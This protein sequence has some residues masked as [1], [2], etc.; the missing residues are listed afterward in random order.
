M[1]KRIVILAIIFSISSVL[2]AGEL[3]MR[4]SVE[5]VIEDIYRQLL[6]V[7]EV[8]YEELQEELM[9]FAVEPIDLNNSTEAELMR[10]RF[11]TPQQTDAILLYA[12]KHPFETVEELD[13]ISE[14][15]PYEVRNLKAFVT[16]KSKESDYQMYAKEVFSYAKHEVTARVDV[17]NIENYN[18]DPVY[19]QFKY[20]FNYQNRVQFGAG[21]CRNAGVPAKEMS[22]GA[23][24]QLN[25]I[26]PH[27]H[28]LVAGNYQ[29]S[30]GQGLVLNSGFHMGKSSYVLTAGNAPEGLKKYSSAGRAALH[31]AGATLEFGDITRLKTEVSVL[32]GMSRSNDSAWKHTIG[33]NLTFKHRLLKVGVTAVEN[34]Y[35]DSLRYY[36]ETAKYNQNYFR[37]NRQAVIGVNFRYNY[38][39]FDLFGEVAAAQNKKWGYGTEIGCR[40][41]PVSD[42]GL[43]VLC[44]YYSPTFDNTMGYGFSETSRI[45]DEHGIYLGADIKRLKNWR[46]EVYGDVFRFSGIKYGINFAPS[47]GYD[48]MGQAE[49]L[50][51]RD[52]SM[53]WR[54]R[55][56]DKGKKGVYSLRY[57]FNWASSGWQLRT[58]ADANFGKDHRPD[59]ETPVLTYGISV[60]QDIQ[61][62]FSQVPIVLQMRLQGFDVRQWDNRLYVYE[63][64]VLYAF[65]IPAT[66]GTGGRFYLNFRWRILPQLALYLRVSETIYSK[67]WASQRDIPQ[68]RTDIHLLLRATL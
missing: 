33:A 66:Y 14:L 52:W 7:G 9:E 64:D 38:G 23:Y 39:W 46:F 31:G 11:L 27:L 50:P 54:L 13:L 4:G 32:Y 2:L 63:N 60:H 29:A 48:V 26:A 44:R 57:Q 6:E 65:S 22:Y 34:L 58:Q 36:Y 62:R 56:R 28:T 20:K 61:Y 30:F 45:N 21:L 18:N 17:R 15:Q 43:V 42:V 35:S 1:C 49:W 24:L 8:D 5:D 16:V 25:D 55:A 12:Y 37:G 53:N 59:K 68:Y 40:F 10:L 3:A 41:L 47:M 51:Q 19:G 67:S